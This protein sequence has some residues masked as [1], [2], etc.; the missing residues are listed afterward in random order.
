MKAYF[1]SPLRPQECTQRLKQILQSQPPYSWSGHKPKPILG[2]VK[3]DQFVLSIPHGRR[4][5]FYAFYGRLR[6]H[7]HG[8][9]IEIDYRI[10]TPMKIFG[11]IWFA[12]GTI[13]PC[14]I[15]MLVFGAMSLLQLVTS[16]ANVNPA[17]L[18]EIQEMLFP[19]TCFGPIF[20]L[21]F[22]IIW[23]GMGS[24]MF[25]L[26]IQYSKAAYQEKD[27]AR[28][29]GLITEILEAQQIKSPQEKR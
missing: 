1:T 8:S 18:A 9:L 25:F 4:G 14:G 10:A 27:K 22:P 26:I 5:T 12:I 21:I 16:S 11:G 29:F 3:E 13:I 19:L 2:Q 6:A 15:S 24:L 7:P 20:A 28:I 23:V 17:D